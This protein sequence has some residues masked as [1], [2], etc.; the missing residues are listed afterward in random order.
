M[1]ASEASARIVDTSVQVSMP[2]STSPYHGL[3]RSTSRLGSR[4]AR[5]S[6]CRTRP[7]ELPGGRPSLVWLFSLYWTGICGICGIGSPFPKSLGSVVIFCEY[8]LLTRSAVLSGRCGLPCDGGPSCLVRD[9]LDSFEGR[10][11]LGSEPA[12]AAAT[13][14]GIGA[15]ICRGALMVGGAFFL[16]LSPRFLRREMPFCFSDMLPARLTD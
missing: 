8:L 1:S 3:H 11:E 4:N 2:T 9:R 7:L 16:L 13:P 5:G 10:P 15:L 6:T 12:A 14:T